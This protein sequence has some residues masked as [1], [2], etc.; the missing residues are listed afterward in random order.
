MTKMIRSPSPYHVTTMYL[1]WLVRSLCEWNLT[2]VRQ[3][4]ILGWEMIKIRELFEY[5]RQTFAGNTGL[6]LNFQGH[7]SRQTNEIEKSLVLH[8]MTP[9]RTII[10]V[11]IFLIIDLSCRTSVIIIPVRGAIFKI[12]YLSGTVGQ[13]L[14]SSPETSD[15]S[16]VLTSIREDWYY[17]W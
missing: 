16:D 11:I 8:E 7:L 5:Q 2:N 6:D 12:F 1:A 9:V 10:F 13:S 17:Q 4:A 14:R 3:I 15:V